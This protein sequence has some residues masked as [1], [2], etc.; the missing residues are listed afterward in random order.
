MGTGRAAEGL[1]RLTDFYQ[2]MG[3]RDKPPEALSYISNA[4]SESRTLITIAG[5]LFGFLLNVSMMEEK[6]DYTGK[7]LLSVSLVLSV[8]TVIV[9]SMPVIY[10]HIEFPY[11]D[12]KKFLFRYHWFMTIGFFPFLLTIFLS[13][14]FALYRLIGDYSIWITTVVFL[15]SGVIYLMRKHSRVR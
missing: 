4:I 9:F 8:F 10:H 13:S 5:V 11:K 12:P 6:V 2:N 14:T 7:L 1:N 3:A 15:L